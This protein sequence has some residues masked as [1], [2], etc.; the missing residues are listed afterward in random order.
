[1]FGRRGASAIARAIFCVTF[2]APLVALLV[3]VLVDRGVDGHARLSRFPLALFAVDSIA[4][5]SARNSVIFAAVLATSALGLGVVLGWTIGKRSFWGRPVLRGA[6]LGLLALAPAFSALGLLGIFGPVRAWP[7]PFSGRE[8]TGAG[9]SLESWTGFG[10]WLVW[11]WSSLPAATA[12]VTAATA[13]AVERLEPT[14]ED[15][16]RLAGTGALRS[17]WT[18]SWPLVRPAALRAAAWVFVIALVEPGAPLILGLRRTLAYQ[19]VEAA[20]RPSAFPGVAAWCLLATA[21]AATIALALRRL[22][23]RPILGEAAA[24]AVAPRTNRRARPASIPRASWSI[25]FLAAWSVIGWIPALGLG[26]LAL[27][28][29]KTESQSEA[30]STGVLAGLASRVGERAPLFR[31]LALDSALLGLEVAIAILAFFWLVG[32]GSHRRND[33]TR[34]TKT[35]RWSGPTATVLVPPLMIGA[36]GL[37][38]GCLAQIAGVWL[39]AHGPASAVAQALASLG[40][41][42]DASGNF[43]V[44]L[45]VSVVLVTAPGLFSF[46]QPSRRNGETARSALESAR[47]AGASRSRALR[48][49]APGLLGSALGRFVLA[50][51]LAATNLTPALLYSTGIEPR[52]LAPAV[53]TLAEGPG[54]ERALAAALALAILVIELAAFAVAWA[55]G[56]LPRQSEIELP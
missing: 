35:Q 43:S 15:A 53:L 44:V 20:G 40:D 10:T 12:L 51:A 6:V 23:G 17:W 48:L 1:M 2:I 54:G 28:A 29:C 31:H 33:T 24:H 22:G 47:L 55:C 9:S 49:A 27:G 38:I 39:S 3:T 52:T 7:W 21:I 16:A 14:W 18:V 11:I 13:A 26:R 30:V 50:W 34:R 42:F 37:A 56:A 25:A 46:W 32:L 5:T 19:I 8:P 45:P 36:G 41:W 4:R